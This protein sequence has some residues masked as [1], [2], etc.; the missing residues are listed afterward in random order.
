MA[1]KS[2]SQ[3]FLTR[4]RAG[5]NIGLSSNN[6]FKDSTI[7]EERDSTGF[8]IASSTICQRRFYTTCVGIWQHTRLRLFYYRRTSST[9]ASR[10]PLLA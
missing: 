5:G 10:I 4:L 8:G 6:C 7:D 1:G 9:L 3:A 2:R